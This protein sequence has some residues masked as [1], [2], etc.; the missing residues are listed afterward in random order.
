MWCWIHAKIMEA[1]GTRQL[2][3]MWPG[4]RN[5]PT[6]DTMQRRISHKGMGGSSRTS[7]HLDDRQPSRPHNAGL[8]NRQLE[9]M[10]KQN[11]TPHARRQ[12]ASIREASED[13]NLIGWHNLISSFISKQWRLIQQ[14][15]LK[16]IGSMKSP[17]LWIS[18]FQRR[19]WEIPWAL[20]QHRNEFLHNDGTTIHFQETVAINNEIRAEYETRGGNLPVSYLHLFRHPLDTLLT[21]S[22]FSR[23][24]WLISVWVARDHHTPE[25]GRIRNV[26]AVAFYERWKKQLK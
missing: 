4:K 5:Y 7:R 10:E 3:Q 13:Q 20:W 22:I 25:H 6:C 15:H 17:I 2:P 8:H 24:E 9:R 11:P 21:L 23:R 14:T 16:E 26:I 1:P 19:I 18:R 12:Q